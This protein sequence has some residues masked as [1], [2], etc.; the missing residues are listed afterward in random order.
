MLG[1]VQY[2]LFPQRPPGFDCRHHRRGRQCA[3]RLSYDVWG[4]R[5]VPNGAADPNGLL[6]GINTEHGYTG[7]EHMDEVGLINMN[8]RVYDPLIARFMSADPSI[9]SPGNLQSYNRYTYGWNNPLN[10]SDPS[11]YCWGPTCFIQNPLSSLQNTLAQVTSN[12][13]QSLGGIN[14]VG[15]LLQIAFLTSPLGQIYGL[16][17]GDWN[18]VGRAYEASAVIAATYYLGG[19]AA[20]Q[21]TTAV[22][23]G[24]YA[25]AAGTYIAQ[26]AAIGYTSGYTMARIYGASDA[27]ARQTGLLAAKRGAMSASSNIVYT[28]LVGYSVDPLPGENRSDQTTYTPDP[29]TGRIKAADIKMNVFGNNLPLS[30]NFWD[31]IGKQGGR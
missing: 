5:R 1:F 24:T 3:R 6:S 11:G 15:G 2:P 30:G 16:S 21:Y 14:Y 4:K 10:S 28:S 29:V 27:E 23:A 31:D 13:V 25:A 26:S 20:S 18:S 9:Q 12:A 17:T 7:H 8:G 22:G 19:A